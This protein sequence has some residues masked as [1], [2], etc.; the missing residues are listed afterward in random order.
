MVHCRARGG[1]DH[2]SVARDRQVAFVSG[3]GVAAEHGDRAGAG[4]IDAA[5]L[6]SG[7]NGAS[8]L[9]VSAKD[10]LETA[11]LTVAAHT[12]NGW[13]DHARRV[14]AHDFARLQALNID[15]LHTVAGM[16]R[17]GDRPS[18]RHS[19]TLFAGSEREQPG[20]PDD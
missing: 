17:D 13:V 9:A 6:K 20:S 8:A 12:Q 2:Q 14:G 10:L 5:P 18:P 11:G 3:A 7:T 15:K 19:V 16:N 1:N 4:E